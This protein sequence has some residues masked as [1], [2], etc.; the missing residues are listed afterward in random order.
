[1]KKQIQ[2]GRRIRFIALRES[3]YEQAGLLYQV[4]GL[5]VRSRIGSRGAV[6]AF[7]F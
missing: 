5:S 7:A 6:D 2:S 1:M 4:S 3:G